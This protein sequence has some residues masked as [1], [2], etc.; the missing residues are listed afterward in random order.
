[1]NFENHAEKNKVMKCGYSDK[2]SEELKNEGWEEC[3]SFHSDLKEQ[4]DMACDV[5]EKTL[6]IGDEKG[7][8]DGDWEVV[9]ARGESEAEKK[10]DVTYIFKRK[11]QKRKEWEKERGY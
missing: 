7:V 2:T 5:V 8:G 9:L 3:Y 11:T 1:M 10:D 4:W 6:M